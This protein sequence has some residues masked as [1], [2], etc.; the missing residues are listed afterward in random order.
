MSPSQATLTR[1]HPIQVEKE[2]DLGSKKNREK[3]SGD[4]Q[5][6]C[7]EKRIKEMETAGSEV[8]KEKKNIRVGFAHKGSLILTSPSSSTF[9]SIDPSYVQFQV[10]MLSKNDQKGVYTITWEMS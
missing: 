8:G 5:E 2:G 9:P 4:I 7:E 6:E 3:L 10:H 1:K